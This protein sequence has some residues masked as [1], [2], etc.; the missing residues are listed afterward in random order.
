MRSLRQLTDDLVGI[1]LMNASS[2][3]QW[4]AAGTIYEYARMAINEGIATFPVR[5]EAAYT[6]GV[7]YGQQVVL[8]HPVDVVTRVRQV[9]ATS[10]PRDL[11][12]WELQATQ[13]T[14]RLNIYDTDVS[15][16]LEVVYQ[17]IQ[18]PL[19][20]DV[21]VMSDSVGS[22]CV[23]CA[24]PVYTWPKPPAMI[25]F[26]M[27]TGGYDFREVA[28]YHA[29]TADGF[30]GLVRG[31]EGAVRFWEAGTTV[32][33]CWM[34]DER[35]VRPVMLMAQ[36]AMYETWIRD[37]ATYD[38]YTA[39]ASNQAMPLEDLQVL[40]RDLEGR[41]RIAWKHAAPRRL[42]KPARARLR[43]PIRS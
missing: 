38:Q 17:Y 3:A 16:T 22:V 12:H 10:E 13:H 5:V 33:A 40:I 26:H 7:V 18:P 20:A 21:I 28:E 43:K 23:T 42:P 2:V 1:R 32:S 4:K 41:A 31:I 6:S 14:L 25:E 39:I 29:V 36:A 9:S 8:P 11:T 19:P 27:S 34:A 24:A 30:S 15:G 37:R 35:L